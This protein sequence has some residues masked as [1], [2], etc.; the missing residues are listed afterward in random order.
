[1][2]AVRFET[3]GAAAGDAPD[4]ADVACFVGLVPRRMTPGGA[5]LYTRP[6]ASVQRWLDDNGWSRPPLGRPP[7]QLRALLDVPVPCENWET[8]DHLF[9]WE[10]RPYAG[11]ITGG[12]W[13]GAAVRSFF[14]QGGRRCYVI[15]VGDP[16]APGTPRADRLRTLPALIPGWGN[17]S[18]SEPAARSTWRGMALLFGLPDVSFVVLPD[19]PEA[20]AADAP[21]RRVDLE[22][23]PPEEV[24]VE[25][26]AGE[27]PPPV[28]R[29]PASV[30]APRCDDT[31]FRAW[32]SAVR[33]A[34]EIVRRHAREVQLIAA[35]PLPA[36]GLDY[37][38]AA[39]TRY[40]PRVPISR[41]AET[42]EAEEEG[43]KPMAGDTLLRFLVTLSLLRKGIDDGAPSLASAFVQL[44]YPWLRT[45]GSQLLPEGLEGPEGALAGLLAR[46][47]LLRGT[48]LSAGA[49]EVADVLGVH[50]VVT[51]DQLD[52][53][54]QVYKE[55][56]DRT[57]AQ[58][59]SLFGPTPRGIRLLSDVTTSPDEAYRP[60]C[61]NRL[62]AAVVRAA[63]RLGEEV[64]F[65]GHGE[66]TWRRVEERLGDLL[67]GLLRAGALRGTSA[68]D[69][70]EVRCDRTTMTQ[71]DVDEGRIVARIVMQ[72]SAPVEEVV[73]VLSMT[74]GGRVEQVSAR[75]AA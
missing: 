10:G 37:E 35:L 1:M 53:P 28:D 11:G 5:E 39:D 60:A 24:F 54:L 70:F 73:V 69:A 19:L 6:P 29:Y 17:S 8:F 18:R 75:E 43:E 46:N 51:R 56:P 62:I 52:N 59:V 66:R 33:D 14:A 74:S 55:G 3:A 15:R 13:L 67:M 25:C 2:G 48:Y 12:T 30:R 49:L 32:G 16:W 38:G 34:A 7:A 42:R 40:V 41:V 68:A 23:A 4:R 64:T 31:G 45:P 47:A 71:N 44:V 61:V 26:S 22:P 9:A 65:E 50:P 72:P 21:P 58:R 63:R 57:L 20:C 36:E 27:A